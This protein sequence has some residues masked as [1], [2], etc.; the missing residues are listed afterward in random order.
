MGSPLGPV[1]SGIIMV[2]LENSIAP[3]FNSHLPFWKQYIDDI[4]TIVKEG[5]INHVPQ[6]LN[7][8]HSN[9]QFTFEIELSGRIPRAALKQQFTEKVQKQAFMSTGPQLHPTHGNEEHCKI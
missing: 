8:F 7:S 1:L 9:I 5:S 4:L 2:E 3:R 6:Q